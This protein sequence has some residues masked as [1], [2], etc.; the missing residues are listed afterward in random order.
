MTTIVAK[1]MR[2]S[3]PTLQFVALEQL[4]VD[5]AYQRS[6]ETKTSQALIRRIA[7]NWDWSLC[8]PLAVARRADVAGGGAV[9]R[10][11]PAPTFD[12]PAAARRAP[13]ALRGDQLHGRG[14]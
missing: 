1:P 10:R 6:L 13:P 5:S 2:G 9:R 12:R 8:Q 11:R 14:R 4:Q 7:T 3:P